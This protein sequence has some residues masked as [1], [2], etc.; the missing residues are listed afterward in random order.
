MNPS[1]PRAKPSWLFSYVAPAFLVIGLVAF[2][3]VLASAS[4]R[5]E[6]ED[7]L[8]RFATG[9]MADLEFIPEPPPQ[10]ALTFLDIDGASVSL[11]DRRGKVVVLNVW[12]TW[13]PPCIAELPTLGALQ[14]AFPDTPFEVVA[15]SI[16]RV[17]ERD[18]AISD[19]ADLAG[20]S[21]AF[22]HDPNYAMPFAIKARGVPTTVIYD[23]YGV[24]RAR[25]PGEADWASPE[26]LGLVGALIEDA[27]A[28][29]Y[30]PAS[31]VRP[32]SE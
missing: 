24:E 10:P 16:D 4:G 1:S 5:I 27:Q 15:V 26:A 19:L 22:Y 25:L 7:S 18:N 17:S 8:K 21:L 12:A 31:T 20:G 11:F 3:Y 23:Q 6:A 28:N 30:V 9:Q 2:V 29:P 13:C 14:R 32:P